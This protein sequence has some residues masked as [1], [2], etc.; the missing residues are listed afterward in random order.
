MAG[1]ISPSRWRTDDGHELPVHIEP[2][3]EVRVLA[4]LRP[5]P[6]YGALPRWRDV[7]P[8]VPRSSWQRRDYSNFQCPLLD[9]RQTSSCVGHGADTGFTRAWLMAGHPLVRFSACYIYGKINGGQDQ[10]AV[11]SDAMTQLMTGGVCLETTVPEGMIYARDFPPNADAEAANYKILDAYHVGTFDEIASAIMMGYTVVDGIVVGDNFSDL[12]RFG[13]PPIVPTGQPGGHC[14]E[15][16]GLIQLPGGVLA[17]QWGIEKQNSWGYG[18]AN[19]GMFVIGEPHYQVAAQA[20]GL[21]DAFAIRAVGD[22]PADPDNPPVV[23]A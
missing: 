8:I 9:Q 15:C 17:G 11:V 3:G 18:W 20:M 2:S 6:N 7:K 21:I 1:L 13:V 5:R 22:V 14:T 19:G 23:P 16:H 10:G 12:D 4:A